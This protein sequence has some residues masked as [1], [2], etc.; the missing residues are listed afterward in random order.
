MQV[1]ELLVLL[2][3]IAT[4]GAGLIA[5]AALCS[6]IFPRLLAQARRNLEQMPRRSFAVGLVNALFF[7]LL[8]AALSSGGPLAGLLS[9]LVFTGLLS[10]IALGLSVV[11]ALIG[12]RIAPVLPPPFQP[13]LGMLL[14]VTS[15][16]IPLVGWIGLSALAGLSG[17]GA[18][19]IALFQRRRS[20][21][22]ERLGEL[23]RDPT[24]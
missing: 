17:Y 21:T 20:P 1:S 24:E 23:A 11:A 16:L 10:F 5:C 7:G 12:V 22:T 4:T 18:V 2:L 14:L 9:L 13:M 19:I 6:A 8:G 3:L 15:A